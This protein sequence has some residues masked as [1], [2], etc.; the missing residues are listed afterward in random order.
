MS[1]AIIGG[2]GAEGS[3]LALRWARAGETVVIGS[4]DPQRALEAAA[5]LCETAPNQQAPAALTRAGQTALPV[6]RLAL[7][8]SPFRSIQAEMLKHLKPALRPGQ[9]LRTQ[10][11]PLQA[12][13]AAR[14][15]P[16]RLARPGRP[17]GRGTRARWSFGGVGLS[18]CFS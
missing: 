12:Q 15:A 3:G 1:I 14:R 7:S 9:I 17:T 13:A 5:K 8:S 4:R 6:N 16:R 11:F 18:Q 2:T 10:R